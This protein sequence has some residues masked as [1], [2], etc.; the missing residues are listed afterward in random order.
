MDNQYTLKAGTLIKTGEALDK[1]AAL[2]G[3][4]S[5]ATGGGGQP[6]EAASP[7]GSSSP[8]AAPATVIDNSVP[9]SRPRVVSQGARGAFTAPEAERNTTNSFRDDMTVYLQ[10]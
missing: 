9:R 3:G 6:G 2:L 8:T 4:I 5:M 10:G 7:F 1:L